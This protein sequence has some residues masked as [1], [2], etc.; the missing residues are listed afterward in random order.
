MDVFFADIAGIPLGS[1]DP[2]G[3]DAAAAADPPKRCLL[4]CK[5]FFGESTNATTAWLWARGLGLL[6]DGG[7]GGYHVAVLTTQG[8]GDLELFL[9]S[10]ETGTWTFKKPLVS[11][12]QDM[13]QDRVADF[14]P[15][16]VITVGG[17]VL[18]FVDFW[19]GI[20]IGDVLQG[21]GSPE[22]HHIPLPFGDPCRPPCMDS[23]RLMP[24]DVSI[25]SVSAAGQEDILRIRLA[26]VVC[27]TDL[28][29]WV[30]TTW[31]TTTAATS[32][33]GQL[34]EWCMD[35]VLQA[36]HLSVGDD[37][38]VAELPPPT[39]EA[40]LDPLDF[41]YLF[42]DRPLLSLH[43]DNI[44]YFLAKG[45][46]Q[47]WSTQVFAIAV[48]MVAKKLQGVHPLQTGRITR[49]LYSTISSHLNS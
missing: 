9:F 11:L 40:D 29:A 4:D 42:V 21:D 15:D 10:S 33:W 35:S 28:C 2:P 38:S 1:F 7:G 17:G 23:Y 24:R 25:D 3:V 18:A 32:P 14:V 8:G 37:V 36:R 43:Q 19:N 5:P 16:K 27:P 26:Y 13:D 22:F 44:V 41:G 39:D 47:D 46:D 34:D 20:L 12:D 31:I 45:R 49:L 30:A 6:S 48:D